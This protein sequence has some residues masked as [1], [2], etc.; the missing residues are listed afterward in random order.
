MLAN[1]IIRQFVSQIIG[2]VCGFAASIITAR[3]L[4]PEG[5]GELSLVLNAS[6]FLCLFLGFSFGSSIVH[7]VST[8]K[9]PQRNI[10]NTFIIVILAL[11]V[12]CCLFLFFFP[13]SKFS[14]FLPSDHEQ[15]GFFYPLILLALF[16]ISLYQ[17]LFS[18]ILSGNRLFWQQQKAFIAIS[19]VTTALYILL[20]FLKTKFHIG[21]HQFLIFYV[22]ISSLPAFGAFYM[23]YHYGR[24]AF[25]FSFLDLKQFR[26]IVNFSLLAYLCNVFQFLSYRMD[27]WFVE[28]FNGSRDLGIYSLAV[29]LA[30]MIWLLPQAISTI[31]LSYSGAESREKSI[32]NIKVLSRV[33]LLMI[34]ITTFILALIIH[35]IIPFLYGTEFSGSIIL[36]RIL[37]L[38]IMP[39][40][41]TTILASYFAGIGQMKINM[42]CS[43]L[44]FLVCLIFDLLLIP[45]HG[46]VGAA[47]ATGIAYLSS[48]SFIVYVFISSTKTRLAD[49]LIFKKADAELLKAKLQALRSKR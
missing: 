36:F 38:G 46:L 44:G 2:L 9:M 1:T 47:I 49:L 28:Y 5:R 19:I 20:F 25:S 13:F 40:S 21:V 39:F 4:G 26:Y 17:T 16:I 27:F 11:S 42:Y 32:Q 3:I 35:F 33:A 7:V 8:N 37:L 24:P 18:S 15:Y 48:T 14:F 10:I 45:A 43:L 30:Q 12:T 6:G 31:L 22:I 34:L 23:F 29:N 41:I